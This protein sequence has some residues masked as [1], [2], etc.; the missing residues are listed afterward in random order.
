MES[1]QRFLR[2]LLLIIGIILALVLLFEMYNPIRD[3]SEWYRIIGISDLGGLSATDTQ[4]T[5]N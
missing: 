4:M 3:L 1:Q 5:G 2:Q